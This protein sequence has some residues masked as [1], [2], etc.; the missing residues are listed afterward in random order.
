MSVLVAFLAVMVVLL[1]MLIKFK[2]S[3]AIGLFVSAIMMA[4]LCG[5]PTG[6]LLGYLGTGFGNTMAS[7]GLVILFG[8]IFGEMLAA[9]GATEE[10]AKGLLRKFGQKNDLLALNLAGFIVA[11]PVYFASGYIMLSPLIN[12]LRKL[13]NKKKSAY[14]ASL[15]VG[16]LLTHCVVAPTPGPVAVAT[17]IGADLGW[18]IAY[19]LIVALPASLL[20]G[21]QYGNFI[22]SRLTAEEKA[23]YRQEV[24]EL[25]NNSELLA[26]DPEKPSAMTAFNLI[27]FPIA[28]II[29]GSI[30]TWLL[31]KDSLM[32][33]VLTFCG[34]NNIALFLAL[35]LSAFVLRKYIV[36]NTDS[37]IMKFVDAASDR[38][39]NILMVIGTGGCFGL[40]LQKSGLGNALVE[41]L[42]S[43]NL[44]IVLLAFLLAMIIRAAVGSATVA[45]LT[46][47]SI[48]GP[49]A[50]SMGYSP[51]VVGLAI[52]C[53]TVGMT[54]PTD[55]AFWLPAKYNQL[56][57]KEAFTATTYSTTLASLVGFAVVLILQTFAG[58]L[59]GMF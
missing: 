40:I 57:V 12:S 33:T 55:A 48:V 23:A 46:V 5:M 16:L 9:S 43:W 28:L 11:I 56:E 45:M 19:G 52:C 38:L 37:S 42:S 22:N 34:N 58:V 21:W 29:A 39:G 15:F 36:K 47:V 4:V 8:G 20:C 13:T 3:P 10:M 51:V 17:Q 30:A 25:V 27:L 18:F 14:A 41:L 35:L 31:P 7:L 50:V 54:L 26:P 6:E 53:G 24:S 32:Y 1:L 2:V 44:P 59:P 49:A